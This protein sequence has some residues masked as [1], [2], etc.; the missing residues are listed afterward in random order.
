VVTI[1]LISTRHGEHADLDRDGADRKGDGVNIKDVGAHIE[2]YSTD[3]EG[4]DNTSD[5]ERDGSG[6]ARGARMSGVT[7]QRPGAMRETGENERTKADHGEEKRTSG[8]V[9]TQR[10]ERTTRRRSPMKKKTD[11]VKDREDR[12]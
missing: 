4:R 8:M 1:A 12:G 3:T 9:K 11:G 10:G 7:A 6:I 2:R 5:F